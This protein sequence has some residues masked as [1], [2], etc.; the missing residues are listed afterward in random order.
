[1]NKQKQWY[2]DSSDYFF[3]HIYTYI[4]IYI[5]IYI[6]THVYTYTYIHI[7]QLF[8]AYSKFRL[9]SLASLLSIL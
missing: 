7:T 3:I 6:Y 9:L 2:P 1:M 8:Y 4:Y 5:Y